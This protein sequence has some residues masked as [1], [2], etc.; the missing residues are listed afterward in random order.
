MRSKRANIGRL[1]K[2]L[3]VEKESKTSDSHGG[4]DVAWVFDSEVWGSVDEVNGTRDLTNGQTNFQTEYE[5]TIRSQK[6]QTPPDFSPMDFNTADFSTLVT[7]TRNLKGQYRIIYEGREI[8]LHS[9][10]EQDDWLYVIQ[11]FNRAT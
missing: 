5:I 6:T 2:P 3:R 1:N 11:G 10:R 7:S 4:F 9:V 8:Y